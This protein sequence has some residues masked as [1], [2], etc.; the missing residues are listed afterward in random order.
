MDE[1]HRYY[2]DAGAK[3]IDDLKPVLGLELTATPKT[4]GAKPRPFGNVVYH[5]PLSQALKDGYV[6]IPAVGTRRDFQHTQYSQ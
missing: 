2:A 5:Y 1:A 6:K 3:A 4:T